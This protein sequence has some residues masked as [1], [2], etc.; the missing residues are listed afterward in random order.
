MELRYGEDACL[1]RSAFDENLNS[2]GML[3]HP[4][5]GYYPYR[6]DG[7]LV[8]TA[9]YNFVSEYPFYDVHGV[10]LNYTHIPQG[11]LLRG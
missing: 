10:F 1:Y 11:V 5:K 7:L 9:I 2:R 3:D 4:P 8:W 6:D